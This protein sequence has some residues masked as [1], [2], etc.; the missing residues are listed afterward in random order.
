M[1]ERSEQ[2]SFQQRPGPADEVQIRLLL[3]V[4]PAQRL[5]TMLDLQATLLNG[6]QARLRKRYPDLSD[7]QICQMMFERLKRNG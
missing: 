5:R 7:L 2:E 1:P 6:W 4:S 3:R